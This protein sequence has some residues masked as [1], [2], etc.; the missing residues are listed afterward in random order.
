[1]ISPRGPMATRRMT[2]H[3]V[4]LAA[5]ALTTL[6]AAAVAATLAVFAG[7]ALPLA[8]QHDLGTAPDTTLSMN[9]LVSGPSQAAQGSAT[10]RAQIAGAMPGIPFSLQEAFWSSPLGLVPGALPATP[11]NA[12]KGNTALLQAASMKGIASH[13]VLVAGRWPATSG[14]TRPGAIPAALPVSA[15]ALLHVSA[16]DVL[17]L[18]DQGTNALVSFDITGVFTRRQGSGAANSYWNLSYIPASGMSA[19][20]GSTTYGPL[21]VSQAAFGTALTM[22]SG[23]WV[24]QP[25]MTAFSDS[26]LNPIA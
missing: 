16:G 8:V 24:G 13:A 19:E 17:R 9:A 18:R 14:G 20:S 25:D 21:I 2:A 26:D 5:A 12:G 7:Q 15:A 10:L 11:A 3:W 1:M 6:V 22:S 23:S 4:V